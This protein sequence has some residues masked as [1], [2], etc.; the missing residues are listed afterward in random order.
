MLLF[1]IETVELLLNHVQVF[2]T[3]WAAARQAPLSFTISQRLL[4]FKSVE[5]VMLSNH[6]IL[7]CPLLLLPSI[8]PSIKVSWLVI[9]GGQNIGSSAEILVFLVAQM[10]KHL[11]IMWETWVQFRYS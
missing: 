3:P 9:S 6:L 10:V 7:C 8:F 4:K 1:G 2:A 5:S 11:L